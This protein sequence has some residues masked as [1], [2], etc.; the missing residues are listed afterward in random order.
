MGI[1]H[2][3]VV[4]LGHCGTDPHSREARAD[5]C[6]HVVGLGQVSKPHLREQSRAGTQVLGQRE[7]RRTDPVAPVAQVNLAVTTETPH[8]Q[9]ED[10]DGRN[11]LP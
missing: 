2:I 9:A 8:R 5:Q 4:L 3:S 7:P 10:C 1:C 6:I 11:I